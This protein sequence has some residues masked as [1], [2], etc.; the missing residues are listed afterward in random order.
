MGKKE[1]AA[2]REKIAEIQSKKDKNPC[3]IYCTSKPINYQGEIER[4]NKGLT[5]LQEGINFG[6]QRG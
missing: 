1:S 2:S 3:S 5:H 4:K 6:Q